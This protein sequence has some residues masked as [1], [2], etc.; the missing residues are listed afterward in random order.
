[1]FRI[2]CA[3]VFLLSYLI[4]PASAGVAFDVASIR[5]NTSGDEVN[6]RPP[7]ERVRIA[8]GNISMTNIT[9]ITCLMDAYRIYRFQVSAPAW[10]NSVRYD[11][12]AKAADP[13]P[14]DQVRLMLRTLLADRFH[15]TFH[16]V[17][18][19]LKVYSLTQDK[20]EHKLRE[21]AQPGDKSMLMEGGVI[22][23]RNYSVA[24]LIGTL[25]NVPFH[26]DRPVLDMTGLEGK[27]DFEVKI[28]TNEL[29]MKH[30]F[31]G[32]LKDDGDGPSLI[33]LLHEQLGLRFAAEQH[34][35]DVLTVDGADK[36][37]TAN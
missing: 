35:T 15:L 28:A 27:Y 20:R 6:N 17:Q 19:D 8:P 30:T 14:P 33:D 24:D 21:A 13:V 10:M 23:F 1:M 31:E 22:V 16:Q 18:K 36:A 12:T 7:E 9:L 29:A 25:S 37:P 2:S 32:M 5:V 34:L 26:I 3:A 11:I 4:F